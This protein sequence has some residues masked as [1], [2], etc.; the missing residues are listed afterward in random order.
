MIS[1]YLERPRRQ[2]WKALADTGRAD[3]FRWT[4]NGHG[5]EIVLSVGKA[6][7]DHGDLR[8]AASPDTCEV[9][10]W[11][12]TEPQ[13]DLAP[14][15]ISCLLEPWS[16]YFSD[17]E[18]GSPIARHMPDSILT[19]LLFGLGYWFEMVEHKATLLNAFGVSK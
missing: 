8:H 3:Y 13:K 5:R 10:L 9:L 17:K 12:K 7:R 19:A 6:H 15:D 1:P 16:R 18:T 2:L 4:F 14:E 11:D